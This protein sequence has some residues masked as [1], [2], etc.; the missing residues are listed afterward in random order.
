MFSLSFLDMDGMGLVWIGRTVCLCLF[1]FDLG[2]VFNTRSEM[3]SHELCMPY[4][5]MLY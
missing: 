2:S 1:H 5:Y 3:V 4:F